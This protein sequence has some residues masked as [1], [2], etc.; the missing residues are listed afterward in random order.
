MEKAINCERRN[1]GETAN[2]SKR[3]IYVAPK[4][5]Q[6]FTTE[7]IMAGVMGDI[8]SSNLHEPEE[9]SDLDSESSSPAKRED[10]SFDEFDYDD[11]WE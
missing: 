3:K 5:M 8:T 6:V 1:C 9:G 2:Q 10:F 4:V 7:S 11:P